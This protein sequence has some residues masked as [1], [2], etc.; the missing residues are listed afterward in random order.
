[1]CC[2]LHLRRLKSSLFPML[3]GDGPTWKPSTMGSVNHLSMEW[4]ADT[5]FNQGQCGG[6]GYSGLTTCSPGYFCDVK[7]TSYSQCIPIAPTG[8]GS[9]M[10]VAA[11]SLSSTVN[12]S[13]SSVKLSS[14]TSSRLSSSVKS[15]SSQIPPLGE[16]ID[17][18]FQDITTYRKT[19]ATLTSSSSRSAAS[20]S[21]STKIQISSASSKG[22][23]KFTCSTSIQKTSLIKDSICEIHIDHI[24]YNFDQDN[25]H[26]K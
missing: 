24:P 8:S 13:S 20:P 17:S 12:K 25:S 15:S 26:N 23:E 14:S 10:A 1:M 11:G 19:A 21:I 6:Q 4:Q 18:P 3:A 5:D 16:K 2:W 7:S 22:R 9:S